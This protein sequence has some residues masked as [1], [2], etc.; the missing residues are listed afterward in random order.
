MT[1]LA[2]ELLLGQPDLMVAAAYCNDSDSDR[3]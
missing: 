3:H 2:E 1:D